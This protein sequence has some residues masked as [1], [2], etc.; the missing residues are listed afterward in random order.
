M[1]FCC[2]TERHPATNRQN[3][4]AIAHV[5]SKLAH[6][7]LAATVPLNRVGTPEKI[8]NTIT[9]LA[10]DKASFITGASYLID[11]GKSAR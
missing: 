4:L 6:L 7:S 11:G 10:S 8:A 1:R 9:F 3:E 5:I 2:I